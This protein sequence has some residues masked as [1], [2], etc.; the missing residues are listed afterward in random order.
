MI[1]DLLIPNEYFQSIAVK[2]IQNEVDIACEIYIAKGRAI[3]WGLCS[4]R[5][6][7]PATQPIIYQNSSNLSIEYDMDAATRGLCSNRTETAIDK[8]HV[9]VLKT[10]H[11]NR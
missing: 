9:K 11:Q 10:H 7:I 8:I 5:T 3:Y 2:A 1:C 4:N 6:E